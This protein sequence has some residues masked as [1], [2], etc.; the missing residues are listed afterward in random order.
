MND[1]SVSA[2]PC[3]R[4]APQGTGSLGNHE[5]GALGAQDGGAIAALIACL[6]PLDPNSIYCNLLQATHLAPIC[7]KAERRGPSTG[8]YQT[9]VCPSIRRPCSSGKSRCTNA[10]A[11]LPG[12]DHAGSVVPSLPGGGRPAVHHDRDAVKRGVAAQ[13][14][15]L[16]PQPPSVRCIS[17]DSPARRGWT[18]DNTYSRQRDD[19]IRANSTRGEPTCRLVAVSSIS[20]WRWRLLK[21]AGLR[22]PGGFELG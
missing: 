17:N 16:C 12:P 21:C 20:N 4:S 19:S 7:I 9:I 6:P 10:H 13:V 11:A 3:H 1:G 22:H 14:R 2:S 5:F 18:F 15:R 8:G